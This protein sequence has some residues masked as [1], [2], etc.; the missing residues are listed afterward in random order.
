MKQVTI[1]DDAETPSSPFKMRG[2]KRRGSIFSQ[3][4]V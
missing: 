2:E 1:C 3:Y 4:H